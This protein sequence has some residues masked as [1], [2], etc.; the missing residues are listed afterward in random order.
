MY[1]VRTLN[2]AAAGSLRV[3]DVAS[4]NGIPCARRP[5][6]HGR[7][8]YGETWNEN[9]T[10][11]TFYQAAYQVI[12]SVAIQTCFLFGEIDSARPIRHTT[13]VNRILLRTGSCLVMEYFSILLDSTRFILMIE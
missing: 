12:R 9:S 6:K 7:P 4:M 5:A 1:V 13:F 10:H 8:L 2:G 11:Y 3:R